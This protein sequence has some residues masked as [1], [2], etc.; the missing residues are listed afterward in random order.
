[1]SLEHQ[2]EY[3]RR[4]HRVLGYIDEHLDEPMDLARLA[5]VANFSD[6]HFHRVFAA[7]VGETLGVY[8]TRRRVELAAARLASQPRLS[9][10]SAA[11]SVGFGSPEAFARAFRRH[12]GCTPTQWRGSARCPAG[13]KSKVDQEDSRWDQERPGE[14]RYAP[15]MK[16]KPPRLE[17]SVRTLPAARIAYLRYQG[18]FGESLGRFWAE[19]VFPWLASNDL[20]GLPRYGI[21]RD[22][23][24]VTERKRCRYDAGV[25]VGEDFVPSLKAQVGTLPGGRYAC[26][27][28]KGTSRE[29]PHAWERILREW[30]PA[31]GY[32]LDSR[33]CFEYY[34]V[35]GEFDEGSGAFT[36]DLCMPIA[37]L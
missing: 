2:S 3:T 28:F 19:E 22:D 32:Q 17:V 15:A 24:K 11:I 18:P 7:H 10:L 8:L 6:F 29:I 4:L 13:A 35:D 36:C 31:S 30:L 25:G 14:K 1:M 16:N 23:P 34:P 33:V 20:L 5:R 9:V 37:R 12:F 21:S 27:R 26:A